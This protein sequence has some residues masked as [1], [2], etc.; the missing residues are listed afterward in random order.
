MKGGNEAT[1]GSGITHS[2]KG[3]LQKTIDIKTRHA[4][5]LFPLAF[6]HGATEEFCN[7]CVITN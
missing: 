5:Q 7:D 2:P 1:N 4:V 6:L 3:E